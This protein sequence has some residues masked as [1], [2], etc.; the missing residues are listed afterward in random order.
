MDNQ[1]GSPKELAFL[2]DPEDV[3]QDCLCSRYFR[4]SYCPFIGRFAK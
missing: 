1:L 3:I 2:E 4:I